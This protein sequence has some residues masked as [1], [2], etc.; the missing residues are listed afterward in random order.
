MNLPFFTSL[1]KKKLLVFFTLFYLSSFFL[2]FLTF[3]LFPYV[4]HPFVFC[5]FIIFSLFCP[6]LGGYVLSLCFHVFYFVQMCFLTTFLI[7]HLFWTYSFF[8]SSFFLTESFP[9]FSFTLL[10]VF[11]SLSATFVQEWKSLFSVFSSQKTISLF[12]QFLLGRMFLYFL[13][14]KFLHV[15]VTLFF[16]ISYLF[17]SFVVLHQKNLKY[18]FDSPSSSINSH[19]SSAVLFLL[20][21]EKKKS[22]KKKQKNVFFW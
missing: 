15:F 14:K 19:V 6:F 16:W 10:F 18:F 9:P 1:L 12:C 5:L 2:S 21:F 3:S 11:L 13:K 20:I 4:Y 22:Q 8:W 7:F 17:F